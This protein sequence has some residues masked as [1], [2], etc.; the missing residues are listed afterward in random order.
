MPGRARS[1]AGSSAS[2]DG[3]GAGRAAEHEDPG[4]A[5]VTAHRD[6]GGEPVADHRRARRVDAE[7]VQ[8]RRGHV[9]ARLADDRLGARARAGLDRREHRRAVG[10]PAVGRRAVGV[11]VRRD[12]RGA[13]LADRPVGGVQLRVVERAVERDDDDV[14]LLRAAAIGKPS[15]R[16]RAVDRPPRRPAASRAPGV[17]L[18]QV[19]HERVDRGDDVLR[20]GRD[21]EAA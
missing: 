4:G 7:P 17:V 13:V 20:V 10:Q 6:V 1:R 5:D 19:A 11:G 15:S 16:S 8:E 12:D 3:L 2:V 9:R 18:V 14:G 21:A